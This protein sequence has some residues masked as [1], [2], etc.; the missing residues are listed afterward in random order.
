MNDLPR[1]QEHETYIFYPIGEHH[2]GAS[3]NLKRYPLLIFSLLRR[4][5]I[6]KVGNND[7]IRFPYYKVIRAILSGVKL[8]IVEWMISRMIECKL[9]Q[10][11]AL[12]FQS[13]IMELVSS[14]TVVLD[15]DDEMHRVFHPFKNKKS[16]L[17]QEDLPP[18]EIP[19]PPIDIAVGEGASVWVPP[20]DYFA[21]YFARLDAQLKE[22]VAPICQAL[23]EKFAMQE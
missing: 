16:V 23:D 12:V 15:V 7:S 9:D 2:H 17:Q 3:R 22:S 20:E 8:N 10:R 5:I 6:P 18:A 4:T 1:T 13:Y 11:C 21:P 14:K 19:P